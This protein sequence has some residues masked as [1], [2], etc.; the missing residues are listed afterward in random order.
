[1][2]LGGWGKVG[3]WWGL[4]SARDQPVRAS[5]HTPHKLRLRLQ[6][7]SAHVITTLFQC[8]R[9][10]QAALWLGLFQG[11]DLQHATDFYYNSTTIYASQEYNLLGLQAWKRLAVEQWFP[12]NGAC[13]IRS[14]LW[15]A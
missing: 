2:D 13:S 10:A 6:R 8:A 11:D 14:I 3:W 5:W 4:S 9:A 1:M 7:L 15:S 12:R